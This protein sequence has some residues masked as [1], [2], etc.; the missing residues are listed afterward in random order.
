MSSTHTPGEES[1]D[2]DEIFPFIVDATTDRGQHIFCK[3]LL[4]N[5]FEPGISPCKTEFPDVKIKRQIIDHYLKDICNITQQYGIYSIEFTSPNHNNRKYTIQ[6][7][8]LDLEFS[9]VFSEYIK[10]IQY[11]NSQRANSI[12]TNEVFAIIY[13]YISILENE[14]PITNVSPTETSKHLRVRHEITL[15]SSYL[16]IIKENFTKYVYKM[17]LYL[18]PFYNILRQ[19][20]NFEW[21]TEHQT[22]FEEIKKLLTEQ[23]S[24]TIPDSNQ[25]FYAMC[26]ASNFGIGAA[27]LQSHNG[28]NKMNLI[29]ANSRL[30]TQAEL[31][32]STLM[33]EC[34]A[35]IYTLTEYE[36]L[37]LGSKHPTVLFTDHKP[38]IF[39]F[40]QKSNPNHRVYRF[41][42]ILMKFPNLHIVWTAGKNL[43]LP[44]TLSRNTPPELLTRKTTVEIPKN[45]KFY[46]AENETSPRLECKYAVK[47]DIEQSQI[48]SLQHFP[49]YLDCQNNHY[50]VDLLGTSTFKPIPYSQWIKNNTQ[51][52]RTKQHP[53]K[54]DHF[55]L[56]EKENLTDKINLSGPQTNDSKYTINQV[57]DLHDPLDTIPLS[58]FEI[59]NIFLP[60]TETITISTLKQY[61]NLDPIIRQLKSW[62]KYKTK[63]VKADSTILGNKTLLRYFRK[64]NNTTIN[65]NTDLLEYNLNE[66]TVPCLPLSMI[67]IAFNISHT[68]NIKGHSGSEKT[69]SNFIQNF[70]FPNAPIWIKVL[71]NDCI[72]CQLNKP[73]PN[74]KQI[75]QK[76]D[77]KG[78]SLYF[79]HRISFDTKGPISPSSEGNSY[80]MVIVDAFTHYVALNP[81]PH[82]NAYY[83]Y[84]TLYEHWIAKF[85]LPEILVTDNGTEFINNEIITLCHLYN[86]KHKPRTSHAPWTNGLVEGMN[87]SLQEYLRCIINGNDTKYTEWSADVK[88]FPLAY[89]SQI[90]TT[91]GMSPYEMVFNQKPRK[92]IMFTANS[93]KNAQGYCQPNKDSICYNLPLHTHDEDHF[94][95]PQI[96]KLASGTHTEWILNRDKKHNE[97]YQKI[98]KKLLQRQ[99]INEQIN[100]RFTPASE[101]KI[102]T[103]VLIPNFNTQKGISKKLQPLRKGPYQI[104]AKPTDVTYKITDSNKKEIVQHRN[105]LLPYYPKE[106]A[107]RELTQLYSFTGLKIIQNE[108]HLKNTEQNDNP[109]ENQNTKPIATK[110]NTQNHKESPKQRK[111]RKMTEQIIPQEQI[112]KSENRK[113]TRLRNQPRKN[114]KIFIPQSKILK[115]VEF[116]K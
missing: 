68:Q 98:T 52:K 95:H 47:T 22:R 71:C 18:R 97:I 28:T 73:Y 114:Y 45:I 19:Q 15:L 67:L 25:P 87:R 69:Y 53:P 7:D 106:Y 46:L 8:D 66:S 75:A 29:S 48:N 3:N 81:V 32:L 104:I 17:Q 99:N 39:L 84:T 96:L 27:L 14:I 50:E 89:N 34:T 43:A 21:N 24:N 31:R 80:I 33:R 116:Q 12:F 65:E 62:H 86:I 56:I 90:T 61:Q 77:F 2:D 72:V 41:Q 13:S 102:G 78:Q 100:S 101:L 36:F 105:N 20:N 60:P 57:F 115:K 54:K 49:L 40:T 94:H 38:I 1:P 26:D 44:D 6:T 58:K 5:L 11:H 23:I 16:N 35:I 85:G 112:D 55:P 92:P 64:F 110:N 4:L 42:L 70:Y 30:F 108:P 82:C 37:I 109:T 107:L 51:Q 59:E 83:A 9:K 113:T 88:L 10:S 91:L 93:H 74:Q 111:N 79:N 76:Q 63:P 103:F